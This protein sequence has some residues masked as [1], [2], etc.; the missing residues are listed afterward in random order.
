[1]ETFDQLL[2]SIRDKV[3]GFPLLMLLLGTGFYLTWLLK[4]MQFRYLGYAL[5]QIWAEQK[6]NSQGDINPYEALMTTLAGA[7]GTGAIVGVS[8]AVVFGGFGA[9]FWMWITALLGMATKYAESLLAIKYRQKDAN[10]EMLGGPMEYI[11]KGLG[12]KWLAILFAVFG[13]VAALGTG[14]LVQVN[15]IAE[16]LGTIWSVDAW[17]CGVVLAFLIGVVVLGGIKTIGQVASVLVPIMATMYVGAGLIIIGLHFDQ[18]PNVIVQIFQSALNFSSLAGG[19]AGSAFVIAMQEGVARSVFSNEAGLGI[20]SMAAAAART[21]SPGRQ[22]MI[23]MTGA[24]ISTVIVCTITGLVLGVTGV[25]G[26]QGDKGELMNGAKLAIHAFQSSIPAG[27]YIVTIG[28]ILFAFTTVLAW[29]YYGE[30]CCEYLFGERSIVAY[31][32]FYCCIAIPG[33]ALKLEQVWYIADITNGLMAVPNLMALITLAPIVV[34]E[35]N[36]FLKEVTWEE[37]KVN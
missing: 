16:A 13:S 30:K 3:W 14:N 23:N 19:I 12:K 9:L 17:L 4:G 27:G 10:G 11:E 36:I 22:S 8:T 26:A 31:R 18:I 28:L 1:M 6:K 34:H 21:D 32:I 2:A 7:I 20:S 24:L 15:S 25:V 37:R 33:A 35:T 29:G 5:R